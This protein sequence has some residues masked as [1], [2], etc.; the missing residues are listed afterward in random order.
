MSQGLVLPQHAGET[1]TGVYASSSF[2]WTMLDG[3]GRQLLWRIGL[4]TVV[5]KFRRVPSGRRSASVTATNVVKVSTVRAHQKSQIRH[6]FYK[7]HTATLACWNAL[8]TAWKDWLA[9]HFG[10]RFIGADVAYH[11]ELARGAST[12]PTAAHLSLLEEARKTFPDSLSAR[13]C[14]MA[15]SVSSSTPF[16]PNLDNA[17]ILRTTCATANASGTFDASILTRSTAS[18]VCGDPA[19]INRAVATRASVTVHRRWSVVQRVSF[20]LTRPTRI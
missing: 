6:A 8:G 4:H 16:S 17:V 9:D 18:S 5:W 19:K 7:K 10:R 2:W 3:S 11:F 14:V 20:E 12:L 1:D 13:R 15:V